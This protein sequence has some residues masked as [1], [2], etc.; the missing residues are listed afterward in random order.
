[1]KPIKLLAT[2]ENI[3][4]IAERVGQF[5]ARSKLSAQ[6]CFQLQVIVAE[7]LNNVVCH[8]LTTSITEPI[9]VECQLIENCVEITIRD[10]GQPFDAPANACFPHAQAERGRGW[11]IINA[12]ADHVQYRAHASHNEL[13]LTIRVTEHVA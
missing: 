8:G 6:A 1:M 12:W 2:A 3:P 10:K 5:G 7:A 9:Q 13:T 11:P 4:D